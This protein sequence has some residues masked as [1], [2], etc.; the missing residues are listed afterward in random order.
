MTVRARI[1]K[2]GRSKQVVAIDRGCS[3]EILL[4]AN[5]CSCCVLTFTQECL[6]WKW[7]LHSFRTSLPN[8]NIA[9]EVYQVSGPEGYFREFFLNFLFSKKKTEPRCWGYWV[10]EWGGNRTLASDF[11]RNRLPCHPLVCNWHKESKVT[12]RLLE[13]HLPLLC[14]LADPP[15]SIPDVTHEKGLVGS[16]LTLRCPLSDSNA[17]MSWVNADSTPI[18]EAHGYVWH[19]NS[20]DKSHAGLYTCLSTHFLLAKAGSRF[21]TAS[22]KFVVHVFSSKFFGF[23]SCKTH[24]CK[25][26]ILCYTCPNLLL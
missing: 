6:P 18:D 8:K 15:E 11:D 16:W 4:V 25:N 17:F 12:K 23:L 3:N 7:K 22:A 14:S 2:T 26:N 20:V 10:H 13:D 1:R 5:S 19:I 21:A 9:S 24:P